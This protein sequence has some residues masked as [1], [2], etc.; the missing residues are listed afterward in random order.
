MTVSESAVLQQTVPAIDL[1]Q[2]SRD[3]ATTGTRANQFQAAAVN[4]AVDF[5]QLDF[6][7]GG[8]IQEQRPFQGSVITR[9]HGE[10]VQAQYVAP[11]HSAG[12]QGV[13]S[14]VGIDT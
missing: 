7:V 12:G 3:V 1:V 13:V 2:F 14:A 5:P 4:L 11:V 8:G 9:D 6:T 10:T